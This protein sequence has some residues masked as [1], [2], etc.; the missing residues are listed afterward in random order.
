MVFIVP[1]KLL[2]TFALAMVIYALIR[3]FA[4]IFLCRC[5]HLSFVVNL[6]AF[7]QAKVAGKKVSR[8]F[9]RSVIGSVKERRSVL[10]VAAV[11]NIG[12]EF[13]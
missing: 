10:L 12:R 2:L 6:C 5:S 3:F 11:Y 7:N 1:F 9:L 13:G 4:E 8:E